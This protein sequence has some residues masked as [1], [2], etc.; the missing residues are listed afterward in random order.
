MVDIMRLLLSG[1][2]ETLDIETIQDAVEKTLMLHGHCAVAR[3]YILYRHD[4]ARTRCTRRIVRKMG[5]A[6]DVLDT[7]IPWGPLGY[8]VFKRTYARKLPAAEGD[9]PATEEFRDTIERVLVACQD[10]LRVN[11]SHEELRNAYKYML[12]FKFSVAGRFLWQLGTTTVDRLG[13]SSLQNCAFVRIDHPIHSF[14]WIFDMLMLGVGVGF[15]IQ[16]DTISAL[17][18]L[19]DADVS[20]TRLDT[21]DADFIV[22]DSREGWV[23]LL[24]RVLE[25]FFHKGRSFTY[26]TLLIRGAGSPISG[27]GGKASGPEGLCLGI[28]QI[29]G[30]L[31]GR[32]GA[33]LTSINCLD[34]VNIIA[35][36]V[37][38]GN[39]RRSAL[40]SIGDADDIDYLRAKRWDLGNVPNWRAMSNNSVVCADTRALPQEFWEGYKGNGEP[41]GL[42]NLQLARRMGRVCAG[43]EA[44]PDPQVQGFNPCAE[45]CLANFETCCLSELFLPNLASLEEAKDVAR[46]AYRICKHSLLLPCHQENTQRI[47]RQNMRMG[48]GITGYMQASEQQRGWLGDLYEYLRE[49]DVTYSGA[50]GMPPSIKLTTVKPS[51]TLSLLPGVTSGAHPGIYQY[52]IRRIRMASDDVLSSI[53]RQNGYPCE[54]QRNFD[55]SEDRGTVVVSFPCAYPAGTVLARDMSAVDQLNVIKHLQSSWSD[56]A[57]SVTIYYHKHELDDI[58]AWLDAHY[59]ECLKTCSFLL[60][61]DHGFQQ[62][63]FEEISVEAFEDLSRRVRPITALQDV[64]GAHTAGEVEAGVFECV[65]GACPVR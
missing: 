3:A 44:Y 18:P 23:S 42:I 9:V 26:S 2:I 41:Y 11:F 36:V 43:G 20:V 56:N 51:G 29:E 46:T 33:R 39:I 35:S 61:N 37:V 65:S 19:L 14:T 38:A 4:R 40:I 16:R 58:R 12:T 52:F 5:R 48:I 17:P 64:M 60:H 30:V 34:V 7:S 31:R 8:V 25:A 27:F 32:R 24:E 22:P 54:Y 57:V 50:H 62:A 10:Q 63:P 21:K 15:N 45:Q 55:G 28:G 47:V 6:P 1:D 13:L 53:C 59:S 49:Y